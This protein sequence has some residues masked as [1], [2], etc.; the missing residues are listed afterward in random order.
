MGAE[1]A[2]AVLMGADRK[3]THKAGRGCERR[4]GA[5]D[6]AES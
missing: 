1:R 4:C 3:G 2:D 5:G 6:C